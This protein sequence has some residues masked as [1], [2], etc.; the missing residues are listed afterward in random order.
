MKKIRNTEDL[1]EAMAELEI[2]RA[3]E[4]RAI[5][6]QVE[7]IKESMKPAN[8]VK[9]VAKKAITTPSIRG[10]IITSVVGVVAGYLAKKFLVGASQNPF[11][12]IAGS[13]LQMGVTGGVHGIR[14]AGTDLVKRFFKKKANGIAID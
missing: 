12:K 14:S 11:K 8:L 5:K 10:K 1:K 9:T 3:D 6:E 2:R 7:F 4:L 13:L